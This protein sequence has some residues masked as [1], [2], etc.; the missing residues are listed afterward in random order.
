MRRCQ[1]DCLRKITYG[2]A[3]SLDGYIARRSGEVDWLLWSDDVTRLSAGYLAGVDTILMGRKTY[4]AGRAQGA[5]A[6]PRFATY[7]FSRTLETAPEPNVTLV[8]ED[9]AAF[10]ATLKT[11]PGRDICLMGGSELAH[12][13]LTADLVDEVGVNIHPVILGEG[14][15]LFLPMPREIKLELV[16]DERIARDCLY[17]VYRVRRE[18]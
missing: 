6:E 2:A 11:Q 18:P 15:P 3:C 1:E 17:A 9:A 4:E 16:R 12:A 7:V 10:V 5:R 13:L 8:R 14:I